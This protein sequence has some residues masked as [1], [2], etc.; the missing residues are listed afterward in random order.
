MQTVEKHVDPIT[1]EDLLELIQAGTAPR[2]SIYLPTERL[3]NK[4]KQNP[5]RLKNLL[6]DATEQLTDQ[7]LSPS[8]VDAVLEPIRALMEQDQ[9]WQHQSD[10][11]AL[12]A[13]RDFLRTYRLPLDFMNRVQIGGPFHVR[14]L[15]QYLAHDGIFYTLGLS[16]GNVALYRCTRHTID[17]VDLGEVPTSLSEAMQYDDWEAHLDFHT[18]TADGSGGKRSAV[19]H[20][21]G[22]AGDKANIKEQVMRFFRALDNGV[23][24]KLNSSGSASPLVLAGLD[25][26]RGLYSEANQY[27]H[28]TASGVDGHPNDWSPEEL[29]GR[30]WEVVAPHF[31]N[32]QAQALD[33]YQQLAAG[34]AGRVAAGV[35]EV[36]PAA[37]YQRVDT[38]FVAKNS[39]VWGRFNAEEG[40]V[41]VQGMP[42][43]TAIDL[44]DDA[45]LHTLTNSGTVHIVS[46][47][48]VP[49]HADVAAI[50]RY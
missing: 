33:D 20:G 17:E 46:P 2:V 39:H 11:L 12:F 36:I 50:L 37:H 22:D 4:S 44:L 6:R 26:L 1:H 19:F 23:R 48:Q 42:D 41:D 28:V 8:D 40:T 25:H 13:S 5:A 7:G 49:E 24:Q 32:E 43:A 45:V 31:E 35:D 29:H 16:Q 15:L 3:W 34:E 30:A 38:L 9:F 18:G 47:D 10:G 14:P 27:A 21:Q